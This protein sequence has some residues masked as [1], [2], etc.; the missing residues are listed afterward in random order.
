MHDES[1]LV[2]FITDLPLLSINFEIRKN[3]QLPFKVSHKN[4]TNGTV[5]KRLGGLAEAERAILQ[6]PCPAQATTGSGPSRPRPAGQW[7]SQLERAP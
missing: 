7:P 6:Q 3:T 2:I 5:S 1:N 4:E